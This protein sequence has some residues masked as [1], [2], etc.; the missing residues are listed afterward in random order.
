MLVVKNPPASAGDIRDMSSVPELGRSPRGGQDNP[1]QYS[2]LSNPMDRG[3]RQA[4]VHGV[5]KSQTRLKQLGTHT[6]SPFLKKA[7][8]KKIITIRSTK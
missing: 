5:T 2:C 6:D 1:F 4:I 8:N 3:A 7:N